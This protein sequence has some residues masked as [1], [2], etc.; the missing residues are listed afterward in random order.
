MMS[1]L[2]A[3]IQVLVVWYSLGKLYT[4]GAG[5]PVLVDKVEKEGVDILVGM[6]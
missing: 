1:A 3:S 2:G 4:V 5:R 6:N